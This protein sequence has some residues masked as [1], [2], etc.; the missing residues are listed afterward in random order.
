MSTE[1]PQQMWR[2][3]LEVNPEAAGMEYESWHFCE[4]RKDADELARLTL[5]G[6]MRATA[7][8]YAGCEAE[9]EPLPVSATHI[10]ITDWDGNALCIIRTTDVE[11]L[12]F[13]EITEEHARTE[14]EGD[15]S[16]AYWGAAHMNAFGVEAQELGIEL[17][18][19][20]PVVFE[21]FECVFPRQSNR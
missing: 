21:R 12:P 20:S 16:L 2:S 6:I 3:F 9:R 19:Q 1:T 4:N 18:D 15:K 14:G 10:V 17:N 13:G 11:V 5:N 8:L 7:S